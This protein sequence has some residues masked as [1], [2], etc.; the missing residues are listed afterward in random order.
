MHFIT[1]VYRKHDELLEDFDAVFNNPGLP[2]NECS[3]VNV[4]TG[5]FNKKSNTVCQGSSDPFYIIS[6]YKKWDTRYQG[7]YF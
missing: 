1:L 2:R 6:Y 3:D 5:E 7:R 4:I